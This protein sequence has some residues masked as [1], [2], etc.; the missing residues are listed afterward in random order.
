MARVHDTPE[1]K[2]TPLDAYREY[3]PAE[4]ARPSAAIRKWASSAT[5]RIGRERHARQSP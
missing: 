2:A 3:R 1:Q 4:P 5:A